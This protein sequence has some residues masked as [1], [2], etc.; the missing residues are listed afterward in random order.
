[1]SDPR[2]SILLVDPD[3]ISLERLTSG[4]EEQ[5]HLVLTARDGDAALALARQVLVHLVLTEIS[6]PTL[7]GFELTWSLWREPAF[8]ELPIL[9]MS[10]L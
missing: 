7:D 9:W 3:P 1:M 8:A 10:P 6:L 4:L 5:G 2:K